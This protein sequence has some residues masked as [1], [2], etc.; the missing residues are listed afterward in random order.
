M[1]VS[2]SVFSTT[3]N[4]YHPPASCMNG[5]RGQETMDQVTMAIMITRNC[6]DEI[7]MMKKSKLLFL[8]HLINIFL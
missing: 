5:T 3:I 7:V 8:K 4:D 1:Y 2:T 6:E